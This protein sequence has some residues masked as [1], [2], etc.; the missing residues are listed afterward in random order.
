MNNY[1]LLKNF[2]APKFQDKILKNN[3]YFQSFI[4]LQKPINS[5]YEMY[6]ISLHFGTCPDTFFPCL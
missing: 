5:G 1:N 4:Y 6:I 2:I 3:S